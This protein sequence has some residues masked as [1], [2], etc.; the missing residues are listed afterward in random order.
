M[1]YPKQPGQ[2]AEAHLRVTTKVLELTRTLATKD[3]RIAELEGEVERLKGACEDWRKALGEVERALDYDICA[4]IGHAEHIR[5]LRARLAEIEGGGGTLTRVAEIMRERDEA[6]AGW[7]RATD[8][9]GAACLE[10]DSAVLRMKE[11]E[12]WLGDPTDP[13]TLK[14]FAGR[15]LEQSGRDDIERC[16]KVACAWSGEVSRFHATLEADLATAREERDALRGLVSEVRRFGSSGTRHGDVANI[17]EDWD[18]RARAALS[19][20]AGEFER[21]GDEA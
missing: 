17:P 9:L 21:A 18:E 10:R 20:E 13:R 1:G 16:W 6:R 15:V 12:R 19:A 11:L 7:D 8:A 3:A 5:A 4:G 2:D 14:F